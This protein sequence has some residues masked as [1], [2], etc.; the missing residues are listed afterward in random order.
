MELIFRHAWFL[1]I[2]V[3]FANY[4]IIKADA[5]KHIEQNP[6]LK[7][8][9]HKV[10]N[11]TLIFGNIPWL[12]MA[13]GDLTQQTN[14]VFD[15]FNPKSYNP[16]VLAFHGYLVIIWILS[17][18]WVYFKN[19]AEF[20]VQHPGLVRVKGFGNSVS[21]TPALI[22]FFFAL[23]LLGGITGMTMMWLVNFPS[24]PFK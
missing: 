8:G 13:L 15:Y 6:S 19:G 21:P 22:K 4:F 20:L 10:L 12:I 17:F 11:A 2:L 7:T 1:F 5:Q 24:F 9:Y 14:N 18:R 23:A 3:T 16:F